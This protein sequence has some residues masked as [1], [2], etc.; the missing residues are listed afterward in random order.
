MQPV[1]GTNSLYNIL[2][3]T[4][5]IATGKVY[6][7]V[8]STSNLNDN[9]IGCGIIGDYS[10]FNNDYKN[11]LSDTFGNAVRQF[12]VGTFVREDLLFFDNMDEALKVEKQIVDANWVKDKRTYNVKIGGHRPPHGAGEKNGNWGKKWTF[13]QK[14]ALS[15]KRKENGK[16]KGASNPN[17]K[18][19]FVIDCLTLQVHSFGSFYEAHENLFPTTNVETLRTMRREKVLFNRRWVVLDYKDYNDNKD[20][21][22]VLVQE[23]IDKSRFSKQIN[24]EKE[25][26]I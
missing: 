12:G 22:K 6:V 20:N 1:K 7:G 13:E 17:T 16:S 26:S 8:H 9:Y 4:T 14:E 15:K 11:L 19:C 5:C 24:S 21:F 10:A 18:P 3:K 2:Y 25:W 23:Y